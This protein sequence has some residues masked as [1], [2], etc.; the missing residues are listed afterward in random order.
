[1]HAASWEGTLKN[2]L[3]G[4][5]FDL[6]IAQESKICAEISWYIF[7]STLLLHKHCKDQAYTITSTASEWKFQKKNLRPKTPQGKGK[8]IVSQVLKFKIVTYV[9]GDVVAVY[10]TIFFAASFLSTFP[11]YR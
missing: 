3:Q 2:M 11:S 7:R 5:H 6:N 1:M 10:I 8:M 9:E 4:A